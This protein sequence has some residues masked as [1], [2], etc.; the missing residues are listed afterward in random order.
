MDERH[1]RVSPCD[2]DHLL[3]REGVGLLWHL[4][5]IPEHK[6]S[7]CNAAHE[8]FVQHEQA[9]KCPNGVRQLLRAPHVQLGDSSLC[10]RQEERLGSYAESGKRPH[11][12]GQ[13]LGTKL[14]HSLQD[15]GGNCRKKRRICKALLGERP[16]RARNILRRCHWQSCNGGCCNCRQQR[17]GVNGKPGKSPCSVGL[18][19]RLERIP[20]PTRRPRRRLQARLQS[21]ECNRINQRLMEPKQCGARPYKVGN[22]LGPTS[23]QLGKDL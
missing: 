15:C 6:Q 17:L 7:F 22:A 14:A 23:L 4:R 11:G 19:L 12:V 21:S 16:G 20:T 5:S 13:L 3:N 8:L 10:Y 1:L 2:V 9:R 18:L